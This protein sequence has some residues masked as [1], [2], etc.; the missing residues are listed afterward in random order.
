ML[1]IQTI[2]GTK[3]MPEKHF[4]WQLFLITG[5]LIIFN[6]VPIFSQD[7]FYYLE[8]DEQN[9]N[10]F[11]VRILIENVNQPQLV[12]VMPVWRPGAYVRRDFGKYV[13]NFEV[14][15]ESV[16]P[17][18]ATQLNQGSWSVNVNNS[19]IVRV[20]YDVDYST[21]RFMGMR[22]TSRFAMIDG[23]M[24]FMY[25]KGKK[26]LPIAVHFRVPHGWK[27]ATSLPTAQA[28]FEY[29]AQNYDHLIDCPVL[30]SKFRDYYFTI[31]Q[32]RFYVIIQGRRN[33]DINQF[34]VMIKKIA[35]YQ[36]EFFGEIPFDKYFF[37]F[38]ISPEALD[39]GGIEY[40]NST[41]IKFSTKL[42]RENIKGA[43]QIVAHQFFHLWNVKR[44]YPAILRPFDYTRESET[45]NL[46]FCEGVTSYYADLTLI[47][48]KVWSELDFL[49]H[50]AKLIE[51][52]Q[53]NPDRLI[54]SVEKASLDIWEN[55]Y[56]GTGV[57]YQVKGQLMGL[58]LDLSIRE[59]TNNKYSLD[60]LMRFMNWWFAKNNIG[61]EEDDIL[62]AVNSL[63]NHDFSDFFNKYVSG[64]VELPYQ[65]IFNYAGIL[66]DIKTDTI[67][68]AGSLR[69][70][71]KKNKIFDLAEDG[72]LFKAGFKKGDF[73]HSINGQ[74]IS[75]IQSISKTIESLKPGAELQI[76]ADRDG[77]RLNLNAVLDK[78]E[79][80]TAQLKFQP[81]PSERQLKIRRSWLEGV[82]Y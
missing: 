20:E 22:V 12:F 11:H 63:T 8:V 50:Q 23:A 1:L 18:Q 39:G 14:F 44:I 2:G 45:K 24:N 46:W 76:T 52:L 54:T 28:S 57:S 73:L 71:A 48:S 66:M 51:E 15:G 72:P 81:K 30:M 37:L 49:T 29:L 62:R 13:R 16:Q 68:D 32:N 19:S 77:I 75:D 34:L 41:Y 7:I 5:W 33:F 31:K 79:K 26:D 40:S 6:A 43:A 53:E 47:R 42:L 3:Q 17:L 4:S 80:I 67:P 78:K 70:S 64:T 59:F 69:L 74:T 82:N 58:L 60:D 38:Q 27:L 35:T 10:A 65:Q 21:A 61:Y 55:G 36:T 25:I 56:H 9:W